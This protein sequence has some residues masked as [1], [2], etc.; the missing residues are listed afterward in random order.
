[1]KI[2]PEE[3]TGHVQDNYGIATIMHK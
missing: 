2:S 1:M 3:N